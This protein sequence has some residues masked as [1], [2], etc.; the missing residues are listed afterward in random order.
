MG[1]RGHQ[2]DTFTDIEGEIILS[3]A[4]KYTKNSYFGSNVTYHYHTIDDETASGLSLD[5]GSYYSLN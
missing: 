4:K 1:G 5:V 3:L 2:I